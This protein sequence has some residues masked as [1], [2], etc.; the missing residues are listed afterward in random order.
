MELSAA[1]DVF[2]FG[3]FRLDRRSGGL[4]RQDD[5]GGFTPVEIGSRA[6]AWISQTREVHRGQE[7]ER[8][9]VQQHFSPRSKVRPDADRVYAEAVRI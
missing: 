1:R 7:S 9:V 5:S 2:M 4:F 8:I 3:G 6:L